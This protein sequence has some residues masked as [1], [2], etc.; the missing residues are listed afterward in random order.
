MW[1]NNP[2]AID[3]KDCWYYEIAVTLGGGQMHHGSYV[4][5]TSAN[6]KIYHY[7]DDDCPI[8]SSIKK[9]KRQYIQITEEEAKARGLKLCRHLSTAV[10]N[11]SKTAI[12]NSPLSAV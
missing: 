7:T 8:A 5:L 3:C 1:K 9:G 2:E 11:S 12:E 4:L 6:A 10:E